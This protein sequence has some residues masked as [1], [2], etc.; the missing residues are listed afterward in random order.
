MLNVEQS[1]FRKNRSTMDHLTN[2]EHCVSEAFAN[3]NF[4][5]GVFL[6]IHKAFDMTWRHGILIKLYAHGVK[7]NLPIFV[8]NFLQ[9]RTFSVKL[10]SNVFSDIFVKE[11]GVP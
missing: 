6:D 8:Y 10:P 9:D 3:K 2:L 1:G 7:G 11:N 4:M 5:A